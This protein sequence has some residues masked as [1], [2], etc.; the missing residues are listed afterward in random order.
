MKYFLCRLGLLLLLAGIIAPAGACLAQEQG[1]RGVILPD[2]YPD[3]FSGHGCIDR[4]DDNQVVID[5]RLYKF[6]PYATFSTFETPDASRSA[7]RKGLRV[8]FVKESRKI[9][10]LWYIDRCR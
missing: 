2:F 1:N 8:G 7:F 5:D 3:R 10:S 6:T 4:I 9:Q